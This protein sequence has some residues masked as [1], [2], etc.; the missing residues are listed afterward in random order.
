M[1]VSS[2]GMT[3]EQLE[4]LSSDERNY[5]QTVYSYQQR[6]A[7]LDEVQARLNRGLLESEIVWGADLKSLYE[8]VQRLQGELE[9]YIAVYLRVNNPSEDE[10]L[11]NAYRKILENRRDVMYEPPLEGE[12]HFKKDLTVALGSLEEYL[13]PKLIS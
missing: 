2:Y 1:L 8:R 12:D 6:F 5:Q 4:V 9:A 10:G 3:P 13:K 11:V 7:S